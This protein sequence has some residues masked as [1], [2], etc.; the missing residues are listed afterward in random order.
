VQQFD[1]LKD[2]MPILCYTCYKDVPVDRVQGFQ[3][4]FW[5]TPVLPYA[6]SMY[7]FTGLPGLVLAYKKWNHQFRLLAIVNRIE[8]ET[9]K[10]IKRNKGIL[11]GI[12]GSERLLSE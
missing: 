4:Y 12:F 6:L 8:P 9:R 5:Y 11:I 3:T 2:S 1:V 10:L 7:V